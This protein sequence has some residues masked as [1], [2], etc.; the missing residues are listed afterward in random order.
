[1][2]KLIS[3][4]FNQFIHGTNYLCIF[5][6]TIDQYIFLLHFNPDS[7]WPPCVLFSHSWHR[8]WNFLLIVLRFYV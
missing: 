4:V 1:M 3:M 7:R 5:L 2:I 6:D 8:T